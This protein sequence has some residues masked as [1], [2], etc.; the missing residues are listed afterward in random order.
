MSRIILQ[1][2]AVGITETI[3]GVS[4]S[5]VA[6]ILG[7]YERLIYSLSILTTNQR[8]KELPFLFIF[9]IGMAIG[10]VLGVV[11]IAYLLKNYRTPTLM[12]FV[13]IIIGFLP[14]LWK[15]TLNLSKNKLKV[16]HYIIIFLFL[17]LV[18]FGQLLGGMNN[19]DLNNLSFINFLFLFTTGIIA[20]TALLLPGISGA[21]ILTIFGIYEI[22][23]DSLISLN[24]PVILS[25]GLGVILGV[26][27]SS[28]LIRYLLINFKIETYAAMIGLVSGSI[29]AI[30]SNLEVNFDSQ[31]IMFSLITF[32][33]GIGFI[34]ILEQT[35]HN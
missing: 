35:Q 6:M 29:Y 21:L 26:L 3:P 16:K 4:G 17:C 22:A 14:Y 2:I 9:G 7:I 8:K 24:F 23:M 34:I 25:I 30:L 27:I 11:L 13:G 19:T 32:F 33:A 15:D 1:G 28:K 10:F 12:F 31:T 5:T 18:I 20:S